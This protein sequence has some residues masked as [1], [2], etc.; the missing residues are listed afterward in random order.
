M[1]SIC[2]KEEIFTE[3]ICFSCFQKKYDI[4]NQ[5]KEIETY[6]CPTCMKIKVLKQYKEIEDTFPDFVTTIKNSIVLNSDFSLVDFTFEYDLIEEIKYFIANRTK[7]MKRL[8][9]D[10]TAEIKYKDQIFSMKLEIPYHFSNEQCIDCNRH[11]S[12]YYEA[13]LQVRIQNNEDIKNKSK[14][15]DFIIDDITKKKELYNKFV[16]L[17]NGFDFHMQ[18][19]RYTYRLVN[20]LKKKF[21]GYVQSSR[22]LLTI[23]TENSKEVY[24][25]NF[26]YVY[27]GLNKG[28]VVE[29]NEKYYIIEE[30]KNEITLLELNN[31]INNKINIKSQDIK[32]LTTIKPSEVIMIS[33]NIVMDNLNYKQYELIYFNNSSENK[34]EKIKS[35]QI[36]NVYIYKDEAYVLN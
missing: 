1:C 29:Y 15:Y 17:K 12:K 10:I 19:K 3:N 25:V 14:V 24:R 20:N 28:Q 9:V 16:E 5:I 4:I 18:N 23:N 8:A 30:I 11:L 36:L 13:V 32:S 21:G 6:V 31:K 27:T 26:L 2:N 22:K 33:D 34:K 7:K 35:G